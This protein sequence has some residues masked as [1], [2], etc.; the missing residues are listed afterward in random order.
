LLGVKCIGLEG[1]LPDLLVNSMDVDIL[2][3]E[4]PFVSST[5]LYPSSARLASYNF[6]YWMYIFSS[7]SLFL[8]SV[9][10]G[11]VSGIASV[12][13]AALNAHATS[14]IDNKWKFCIGFGFN[15]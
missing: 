13:A 1:G 14:A 10:S 7:E 12:C 4:S 5:F 2:S 8:G 3:A 15:M 9:T 6:W 11:A